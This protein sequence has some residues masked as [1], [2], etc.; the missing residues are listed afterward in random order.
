MIATVSVEQVLTEENKSKKQK[1]LLEDL[2]TQVP[3]Q[4]WSKHDT[5]VGLV[6]SANPVKIELKPNVH[7]PNHVQYPLKPE[8][9]AGVSKTIEGL[10]KTSVLSAAGGV[11]GKSTL[12][13]CYCNITLTNRGSEQSATSTNSA[14]NDDILGYDRLQCRL[15]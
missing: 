9:E 2:A 14:A 4:L 13:W 5:D 6:I 12:P 1:S 7:L 15:D 10:I 8:A 11:S 3:D